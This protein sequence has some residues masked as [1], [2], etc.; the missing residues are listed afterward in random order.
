MCSNLVTGGLSLAS[1]CKK[2]FLNGLLA[3]VFVASGTDALAVKCADLETA[4]DVFLFSGCD[5]NLTADAVSKKFEL[6]SGSGQLFARWAFL[7]SNQEYPSVEEREAFVN[8]LLAKNGQEITAPDLIFA[9]AISYLDPRIL[10]HVSGLDLTKETEENPDLKAAALHFA[11]RTD[12]PDFLGIDLIEMLSIMRKSDIPLLRRNYHWGVINGSSS[13]GDP[14][15]SITELGKIS[16]QLPAAFDDLAEYYINENQAEKALKLFEEAAKAGWLISMESLAARLVEDESPLVAEREKQGAQIFEEIAYY[17][18]EYSQD[19]L[20]WAYENGIGVETNAGIAEMW[21]TRAA[22]GGSSDAQMWLLDRFAE[23]GDYSAALRWALV[24]AQSGFVSVEDRGYR[25]AAL[26]VNASLESD[27]KKKALEYLR[28]HCEN[29]YHTEEP[30]KHCAKGIFDDYKEFENFVDL[31][32]L[33]GNFS[34]LRYANS[35]DLKPGRFVALVIANDEYVHWEPLKTP[36][37]DARAIG[38]LLS[39]KFGFEV[40]Y[41]MNADR[42]DTLRAI[43]DIAKDLRF[44]DHLLV[45]YAGHGIVDRATDTAYW[46]P[47]DASRDFQPDWISADE[48]M[49]SL[50]SVPAKHLLLV[51]DSCYSGKLL[52]STAQIEGNVTNASIERLFQKKARVAITS[53][54]NEPVEDSSSGGKHSIFAHALLQTLNDVNQVSAASSIFSKVLG[55]VSLEASQTPQYADMRELGHD[56]GDFIFIPNF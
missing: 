28:Y 1:W 48:V 46:V 17:G 40:E 43:Y 16:R 27:D 9:N 39:S 11:W 50:K 10:P 30:E 47:P 36:Q 18:S 23:A 3:T 32:S 42:R 52:R 33:D 25:F 7:L 34:A 8:E 21:R 6:L 13:A 4:S 45:Y 41:L 37:S 26:L 22:L 51:A 38:E 20:G 12:N 55:K 24:R 49:T 2:S 19:Y 31:A 5:G 14:E 54:G 56:G 53:G 15:V 35:I 44:D 29:N